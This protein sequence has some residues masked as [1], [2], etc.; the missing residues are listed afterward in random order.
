MIA[1][2]RTE[3]PIAILGAELSDHREAT[4]RPHWEKDP[5]FSWIKKF[6]GCERSE[7]LCVPRVVFTD[8]EVSL[9]E[10]YVEQWTLRWADIEQVRVRREN[11]LLGWHDTLVYLVV[12][13][14]EYPVLRDITGFY[15]FAAKLAEKF[16]AQ[17]SDWLDLVE[18]EA[19]EASEWV[20]G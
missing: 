2:A 14:W 11:E 10:D 17:P 7:E 13:D 15:P 5:V 6:L 1:P 20:F 18:E 16:P 3:K 9:T 19:P 4:A 12:G 8:F